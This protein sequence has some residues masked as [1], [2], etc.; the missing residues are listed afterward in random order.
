MRVWRLTQPRFAP[1]LEGEGARLAGGRWNLAG[2]PVVYTSDSLAL[3]ALEVLVHL[4][5]IERSKQRIPRYIAIGLDVPDSLVADPGLLPDL[6]LHE[7]QALGDAWLRSGSS[8]G[9]LVPS[10][11]IPLERNV[12]LNP[13]HPAMAEVRVAVSEPFVFDDRLSY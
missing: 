5:G 13:R 4:P 1:D 3:A 7:S 10:R 8:L 9:L 12:L 11:V 2:I 6:P